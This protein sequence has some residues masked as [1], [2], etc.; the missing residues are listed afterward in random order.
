M[1]IAFIQQYTQQY[2]FLLF[3]R[4]VTQHCLLYH[5]HFN[6]V[7]LFMSSEHPAWSAK[8][9]PCSTTNSSLV[10]FQDCNSY[11]CVSIEEQNNCLIRLEWYKKQPSY[12][13]HIT[14]FG[15]LCCVIVSRSADGSRRPYPSCAHFIQSHAWSSRAMSLGHTPFQIGNNLSGVFGKHDQSRIAMKFI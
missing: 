7:S 4:L 12:D 8:I 13:W 5:F 2:T 6:H 10:T 1:Y 11:Q 3:F 14:S 15:L 9:A